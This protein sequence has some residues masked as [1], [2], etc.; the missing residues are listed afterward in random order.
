MLKKKNIFK[1]IFV[2]ICRVFGFEIIDQSNFSIPTMNKPLNAELSTLGKKSINLPLGEVVITRKVR[3][4]DIIIRTC[5]KVNMLT[6]NKSRLFEK[7]KIEYTLRTLRSLLKSVNYFSQTNNLIIK[8]KIVDH[9]SPKKDLEKINNVFEQYNTKYDLI[10]L[11]VSKFF[12]K[13]Q[14]INEKGEKVSSN[15]ISNMANIHQSLLETKNSEDLIYFVEDDY[16]H[17]K[18]SISEMIFSYER[19]SSQLNNELIICPSD[20]PYLYNNSEATRNFLGNNCHWRSVGESL[21]TFLTSKAMIDKYWDQILRMCEKEHLP[22]EKPLHEIYEK[23]LCI[24][25]IPS[26]AIHFTN[27]NSVFGLSPNVNW[28]RVWEENNN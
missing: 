2:K 6:Q 4:L 1:K 21:C 22:F 12:E 14:K 20:Y 28:G 19:I 23:E 9:D 8:F 5:T 7:E 24:S 3:A 27:V 15:Q 13:I 10:N 25:P 26:L 18:I 11:D 17:E 16:L